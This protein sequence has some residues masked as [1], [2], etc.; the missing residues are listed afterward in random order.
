MQL[1]YLVFGENVQNHFQANFSILTFLRQGPQFLKRIVVVTDAPAFY[2]H[3]REVIAVLPIDAA[4]LQDWQ[5]EHKF[6]WRAKI[7][8]LEF[9][10]QQHPDTPLM[11]LDTDTLLH[12]AFAE[13]AQHLAAG[14]AFMHEAEG[15]LAALTSKTDRR[16]WQQVQGRRF[17]GVTITR[18]H[19]MWNAGVVAIPAQRQPE[20]IGRALAI[21]DAMS[22]Q[23][24]TPR[25]IEQFALSVALAETYAMREARPYIGHYWSTKNEWNESIG[26]FLLESHLKQRTVAADVA[27]LDDF[28]FQLNPVKKKTRNTQHR[29]NRLVGK[30]LPPRDVEFIAPTLPERPHSPK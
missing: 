3:L 11:Y 29:L 9:V 26:T 15:C 22:A 14:T 5:G 23:Q 27:A 25:L 18:Q 28:D 17:G 20:A 6:F 8:A 21:C 12:G 13:L 16:M 7:K 19:Q 1:L 24:V 10:G 2:Q 30:L 4:T